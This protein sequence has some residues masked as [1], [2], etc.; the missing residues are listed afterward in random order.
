MPRAGLSTARVVEEA[1]LL[2]DETGSPA[3]SL[4]TLAARLGVQV[5]SLYKHVAGADDLHRLIS[6]SA[7]NEL[8][9]VLGRATVGKARA[10]AVAALA[11]TYREWA[12]A[13]PGRYATTL[14]APLPGDEADL[15]ASDRAVRVM[16]D[17]LAGYGLT[18]DDAVDATRLLRASLHG[19]IS[20]AA[21]GGFGLPEV[22]RTFA[23]LV[24][25]AQ[26]MLEQWRS[27]TI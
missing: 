9:D 21:A 19:F 8:A 25:S 5:P 12:T 10:E 7:K 4:V 24:T 22:D 27:V 1:E 15:A 13:H 14:R 16:F 6:V 2:A 26:L 23:R 11:T 20:L 18:G 17:A 3:V